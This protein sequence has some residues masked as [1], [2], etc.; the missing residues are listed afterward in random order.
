LYKKHILSKAG[1]LTISS[2]S[3]EIGKKNLPEIS[4]NYLK[5][6]NP[7]INILEIF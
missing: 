7:N 2:Q 3:N 1:R 6:V 5:Y 4:R